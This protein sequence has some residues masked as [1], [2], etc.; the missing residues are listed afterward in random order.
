MFQRA[1]LAEQ[2]LDPSEDA[3]AYACFALLNLRAA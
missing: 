1:A 2:A 3:D